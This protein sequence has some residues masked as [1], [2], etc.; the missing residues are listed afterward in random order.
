MRDKNIKYTARN[1]H[2]FINENYC[3]KYIIQSMKLENASKYIQPMKRNIFSCTVM[4]LENLAARGWISVSCNDA[5]ISE[6]V[7][8]KENN[9]T[10]KGVNITHVQK[11]HK[12]MLTIFLCPDG[13]SISSSRQCNGVADCSDCSDEANC[14]CFVK[15]KSRKFILL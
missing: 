5:V 10:Y 12:V 6:I 2:Y 13:V 1:L 14:F 11:V 3:K 4:V 8:V 9:I 7:C 15:G